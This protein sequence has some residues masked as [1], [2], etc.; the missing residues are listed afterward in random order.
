MSFNTQN[1]S[2][3]IDLSSEESKEIAGS[4]LVDAARPFIDSVMAAVQSN[5]FD[6]SSYTF[7]RTQNSGLTNKSGLYLIINR[8]T[9]RVYL[10][11]TANLAQRKGEHNLTL[12]NQDRITKL[13]SGMR[14]DLEIGTAEDF[15]FV[16]IIIFTAANVLIAE[17]SVGQKENS[18]NQ[19]VASFLDSYAEKPLLEAYLIS[20]L[21]QVFYNEKTVGTF[22]K[23]NTF[24]G[25]PNSGQ[26]AKAIRYKNYAWDSVTAASN[27]FGVDR[28]L[29]REKRDQGLMSAITKEE[30]NNFAGA[31]ITN[32]N[33]LEFFKDKQEEYSVLLAELFPNVTKKR[34][35]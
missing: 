21:K 15:Y 24:G 26:P 13:Q 17:S 16:P 18:Y 28:R 30:F 3:L 2:S 12:T 4:A 7:G 20:D 31:K 22:E 11:G 34:R 33:A 25:S 32:A 5:T 19:Q 9:K 10:G 1:F 14:K 27:T 8:K 6:Y 29:I 23:G 35:K